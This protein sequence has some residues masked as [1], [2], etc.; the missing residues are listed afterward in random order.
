MTRPD[1]G[2]PQGTPVPDVPDVPTGATPRPGGSTGVTPPQHD[3][4]RQDP[5][6]HSGGSD[7]DPWGDDYGYGGPGRHPELPHREEEAPEQPERQYGEVDLRDTPHLIESLAPSPRDVVPTPPGNGEAGGDF[8]SSLPLA[9]SIPAVRQ[10]DVALRAAL[11]EVVGKFNEVRRLALE[12]NDFGQ[13]MTFKVHKMTPSN[14]KM[15]ERGFTEP[16]DLLEGARGQAEQFRL[17]IRSLQAEFLEATGQSTV[18]VGQ[19]DLALG[20]AMEDYATADAN[21]IAPNPD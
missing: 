5:P 9:V 7:E 15:P 21:S 3:P 19:Y 10:V 6:A 13:D 16:I 17:E 2:S 4:P 11:E 12:V 18:I 14:A 8:H 20:A 1:G